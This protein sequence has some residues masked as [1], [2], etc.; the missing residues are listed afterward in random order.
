MASTIRN[1]WFNEHVPRHAVMSDMAAHD[2]GDIQLLDWRKPG[3]GIYGVRYILDGGKLMVTGD[4]GEAVY[5]WGGTLTFQSIANM[6]ASYFHSKCE[7]SELG[8]TYA[9]WSKDVALYNVEQIAK[10]HMEANGLD[11]SIETPLAGIDLDSE[12]TCM[13]WI[14]SNMDVLREADC[15]DAE[16]LSSILKSGEVL[17]GRCI[18]HWLGVK[19]AME[20]LAA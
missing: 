5:V 11:E 13:E 2:L 14:N 6:D 16:Q 3:T 15:D 9:G 8:R 4:L 1:H 12:A 10:D 7:A 20:R 19:M 18:A 17:H